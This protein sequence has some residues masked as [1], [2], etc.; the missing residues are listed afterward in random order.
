MYHS[1]TRS[2][3]CCL[4]KSGSTSASG[5]Q[6]NARSHAAYQGY[7]HL[8][9]MERTSELYRWR[10]P[11]LRPERRDSGGGGLRRDRR[12]ASARRRTRSTA[13]S[14]AGRPAPCGT[15][16]ARPRT[17]R[18]ARSR[19]RTRRPPGCGVR[20]SRRSRRRDASS[21]DRCNGGETVVLSPGPRNSEK[22]APT[23]V[24]RPSGLTASRRRCTMA[25]LN[26]SFTWAARFG[27]RQSFALLDSLSVKSSSCAPST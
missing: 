10:Q 12:A 15:R 11:A 21:R 8:S 25:S 22:R 20:R 4:A 18:A 13:C 19:R 26:A 1:R 7:S 2:V 14:T 5:M 9:G 27:D 16:V 17:M 6:W 23:L 24:P 3:S